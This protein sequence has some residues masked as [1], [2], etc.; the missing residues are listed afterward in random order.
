MP[1]GSTPGCSLKSKYGSG[2]TN[3]NNAC[4]NKYILNKYWI[5]FRG[6]GSFCLRK[7]LVFHLSSQWFQRCCLHIAILHECY[8]AHFPPCSSCSFS[9]RSLTPAW[10]PICFRMRTSSSCICSVSTQTDTLTDRCHSERR[11]DTTYWCF[12][13]TP[14]DIEWNEPSNIDFFYLHHLSFVKGVPRQYWPSRH[15]CCRTGVYGGRLLWSWW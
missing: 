10:G 2:I 8:Y 9:Q 7:A 4:C 15:W 14:Q 6:F 5:G 3:Y 13:I 11:V 1:P 12:Y